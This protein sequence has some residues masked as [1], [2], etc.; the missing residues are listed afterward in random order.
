M[1]TRNRIQA[2]LQ[3]II[4][5]ITELANR[6]K[7]AR[8]AVADA[9]MR[10]ITLEHYETWV[11]A[12]FR[13]LSSIAA[14]CEKEQEGWAVDAEHAANQAE[15]HTH[16]KRHDN[17][18]Y[19]FRDMV[20]ME[21][22]DHETGKT[23]FKPTPSTLRQLLATLSRLVEEIDGPDACEA[24]LVPIIPVVKAAIDKLDNQS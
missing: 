12:K 21:E 20:A 17:L 8:M 15:I 10:I 9:E 5:E 23:A 11:L 7:E 13:Y 16:E 1:D 2:E 22:K 3:A 14:Y 24:P 19:L 18:G 4:Q 6:K